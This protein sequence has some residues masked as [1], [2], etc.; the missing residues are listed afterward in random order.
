MDNPG[1]GKGN[2]NM[3]RDAAAL[4]T[5]IDDENLDELS[6]EELDRKTK[7]EPNP[8]DFEPFKKP[9]KLKQMKKDTPTEDKQT[10]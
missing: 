10:K 7:E 9:D 8:E 1:M 3:V 4:R 2:E 5:F 6:E